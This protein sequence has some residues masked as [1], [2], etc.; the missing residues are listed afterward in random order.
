MLVQLPVKRQVWDRTEKNI[1]EHKRKQPLFLVFSLKSDK[2]SVRCPKKA[3]VQR[4]GNNMSFSLIYSSVLLV[5]HCCCC[6]CCL[7][8]AESA[9]GGSA[10][11]SC[12]AAELSPPLDGSYHL[13]TGFRFLMFTHRTDSVTKISAVWDQKKEINILHKTTKVPCLNLTVVEIRND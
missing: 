6:C 12:A 7:S 4:L 3:T 5:S 1:Y 2:Q 11:S 13:W 9:A 10:S 8:D